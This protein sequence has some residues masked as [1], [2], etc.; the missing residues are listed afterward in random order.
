MY[1][2]IFCSKRSVNQH[3]YAAFKQQYPNA[4][5]LG[6][7]STL[8]E[9]ALKARNLSMTS[10]FWLVT[11]DVV[12]SPHMDLTWKPESWDRQ[13]PLAWPN[14]NG[15]GQDAFAGVYLIP[16]SHKVSADEL[17]LGC[18]S[19]CKTMQGPTNRLMPLDVVHASEN[20]VTDACAK[21]RSQTKSDMYW[22][23]TD[24]VLPAQD[25]DYSWRPPAWDS[26]YVHVW[27]SSNGDH[28]GVYL[29]PH[30]YTPTTEESA[31]GSFHNTKAMPTAASTVKPYD[32]FFMSYREANADANFERLR[33]RFPRAKRVH[34]VRGIHNAHKACA[35]MAETSMFWT[36]DA[37]TVADEDF[38]FDYRPP[39][40][41]RQYLH[42]WHSRNPVNGLT[43]G[44]GAIKLWPRDAVR[45]FQG[46]WLDFTT[47]VGNMKIIA[48]TVATTDFNC[49]QR[50]SWQSG[51]REAVKLCHNVV[52]MGDADSSQRL[53]SWATVA[54][55]VPWAEDS[56]QGA[57][58]GILF[59]LENASDPDGTA[60][61]SINDFDWL[62][63]R[64]NNRTVDLALPDLHSIIK[65][66]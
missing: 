39:D 43:Y 65:G 66:P 53:L 49:D 18:L 23:I 20:R 21:A 15:V 29:I 22:L 10:M 16:K 12:L 6:A 31:Q 33:E 14:E 60:L 35:E 62:A 58:A 13:L 41:D 1:D 48:K 40:S 59:Y 30:D 9:A 3:A 42:L 34:G 25:W 44:W 26:R 56:V 24:D 64:F 38:L 28:T 4:Q 55:D 36:V 52:K 7:V 63:D 2:I 45:D 47:T 51:F 11:D 8:S 17:E 19:A 57:R 46:N 37:D 54:N 27:R 61:H 32:L 50:S 5:S